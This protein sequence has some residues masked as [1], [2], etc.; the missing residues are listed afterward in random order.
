MSV[1]PHP[2]QN[3]SWQPKISLYVATCPLDG[4]TALIGNHGGNEILGSSWNGEESC[5][6]WDTKRGKVFIGSGHVWSLSQSGWGVG[7]SP[8]AR[9]EEWAEVRKCSYWGGGCSSRT[10]DCEVDPT[11][12]IGGMSTVYYSMKKYECH[13]VSVCEIKLPL[14]SLCVYAVYITDLCVPY[15]ID[16]Y[17]NMQKKDVWEDI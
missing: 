17:L 12:C 3:N 14:T 11:Y 13:C 4:K 8:T 1:A 5:K 2:H 7:R 6:G 10:L 9:T 15:A 16:L